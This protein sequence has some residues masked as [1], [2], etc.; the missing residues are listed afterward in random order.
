MEKKRNGELDFWKFIA[1]ILIVLIHSNQLFQTHS[2]TGKEGLAVEFFFIVSGYFFAKTVYNRYIYDENYI[3]HNHSGTAALDF[4]KKKINGFKYIYIV[5]F[6]LILIEGLLI[7]RFHFNDRNFLTVIFDFLL[8]RSSG[9]PYYSIIGATWY[10]SSMLISMFV[11][12]PLFVRMKDLFAAWLAPLSAL[13]IFGGLFVNGSHLLSRNEKIGYFRKSLLV[14][15]AEISLGI[16]AYV[17]SERLAERKLSTTGHILLSIADLITGMGTFIFITFRPTAAEEYVVPFMFFLFTV[18]STSGQASITRLYKPEICG[19]LGKLSLS[20]YLSHL[21]ITH[22]LAF[23]IRKKI[24]LLFMFSRPDIFMFLF[25]IAVEI[26][27]VIAFALLVQWF[28]EK[29]FSRL[30]QKLFL[31]CT[32]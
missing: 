28:S 15:F 14:A 11:I 31:I 4:I 27:L 30:C 5:C 13:L 1:S 21:F 19:K 16:F 17:I 25:S 24:R 23:L 12:F 9:I 2:I 20:I 3:K 6:I 22:L 26:A 7:D 32:D 18:I 10:L 8:L 29:C